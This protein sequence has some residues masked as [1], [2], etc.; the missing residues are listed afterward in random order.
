[1][2]PEVLKG[3]LTSGN[4]NDSFTFNETGAPPILEAVVIK[5]LMCVTANFGRVRK[6]FSLNSVLPQALRVRICHP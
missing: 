5:D 2:H 3:P 6:S 1:M 4:L